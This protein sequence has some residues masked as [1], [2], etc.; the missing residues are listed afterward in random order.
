MSAAATRA[1][2]DRLRRAHAKVARLVVADPVYAPIFTRL[3]AEIVDAEAALSG[4][5]I[6]RARAVARQRA[7][8]RTTA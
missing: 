7:T 2:L 3:E 1:D 8:D 5:V 6:A 4:D